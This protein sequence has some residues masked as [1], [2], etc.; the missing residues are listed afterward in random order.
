MLCTI[1]SLGFRPLQN[2]AKLY[3]GS[4]SVETEHFAL[5]CA[6][7]M[8]NQTPNITSCSVL[9]AKQI[10]LLISRVAWRGICVGMICVF[11]DAVVGTT[12][13]K[14]VARSL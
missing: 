1:I 14:K 2:R 4:G 3:L 7:P 10:F 8:P 11:I 12:K 6:E 5:F 13:F 9:W